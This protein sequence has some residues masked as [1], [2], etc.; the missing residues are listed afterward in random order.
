MEEELDPLLVVVCVQDFAHQLDALDR[1]PPLLGGTVALEPSLDQGTP[2]LADEGLRSYIGT[3]Y[4]LNAIYFATLAKLVK[5]NNFCQ[6]IPKEVVC[7]CIPTRVALYEYYVDK[8]N[9]N[10]NR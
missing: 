6:F 10:L 2:W 4:L 7:F 8:N 9:K 5:A 3:M 1:L